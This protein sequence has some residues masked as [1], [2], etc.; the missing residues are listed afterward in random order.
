MIQRPAAGQD[1]VQC[2]E[3]DGQ[4]TST[5]IDHAGPAQ[6]LQLVRRAVQCFMSGAG[7]GERDVGTRGPGF[8]A[9]RGS[10]RRGSGY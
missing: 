7:R 4:S 8:G 1:H 6:D 3:H 9:L 5:S 2:I 10:L